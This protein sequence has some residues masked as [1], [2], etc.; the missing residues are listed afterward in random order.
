MAIDQ[1]LEKNKCIPKI[2][3]KKIN[4][5]YS[6]L[7]DLSKTKICFDISSSFHEYLIELNIGEH[8]YIEY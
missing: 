8:I 3:I 7:L 6:L 2:K 5:R 4:T 1:S